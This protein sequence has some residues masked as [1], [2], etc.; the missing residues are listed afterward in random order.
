MNDSIIYLTNLESRG[1]KLG[2][3][4]T[5]LLMDEIGNPHKK[6]KC[7]Q[8]A[9]TNGKGSVAAMISKGLSSLGFNVG[10]FTSPHL[11]NINERIRIND[12]K[13]CCS[14]WFHFTVC[15]VLFFDWI[16]G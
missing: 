1:I 11:V 4:R 9:G 3:E 14:F 15:L 5:K 8:I 16:T 13:I 7:I 12:D 10:L 6:L 2:L